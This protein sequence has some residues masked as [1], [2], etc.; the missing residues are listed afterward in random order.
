M[1]LENIPSWVRNKPYAKV[2]LGYLLRLKT[3]TISKKNSRKFKLAKCTLYQYTLDVLTRP[4]LDYQ[5]DKFD[6]KTDD[7]D[8]WCYPFLSMLLGD[9]LEDAALTLTF[10]SANCKC[11]CHKCLIDADEMNNTNLES[12]QIILRTPENMKAVIYKDIADQYSLFSMENI[13]WKHP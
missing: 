11:L 2:L 1:T 3:K 6:L 12:S 4:L 5:N 13:F 8:L 9:L 10:N 7:S